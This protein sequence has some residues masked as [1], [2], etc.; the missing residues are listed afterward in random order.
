M[1]MATFEE[2]PHTLSIKKERDPMFM[3]MSRVSNQNSAKA[4]SNL[5]SLIISI[6]LLNSDGYPY[7][8][9]SFPSVLACVTA[10]PAA[11]V[12][13]RDVIFGMMIA[14]CE[15]CVSIYIIYIS[16]SKSTPLAVTGPHGQLA[17][18]YIC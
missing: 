5:P 4:T 18:Y 7:I 9:P 3:L 13:P 11:A 2:T 15:V 6:I 1:A 8:F 10:C 14:R 17:S 12:G 16:V